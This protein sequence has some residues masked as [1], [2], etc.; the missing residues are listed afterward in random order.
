MLI[1]PNTFFILTF[2]LEFSYF[3]KKIR[4]SWW[5]WMGRGHCQPDTYFRLTVMMM[6]GY[7]YISRIKGDTYCYTDMVRKWEWGRRIPPNPKLLLR[8]KFVCKWWRG[9]GGGGLIRN[10]FWQKRG[11]FGPKQ[12]LYPLLSVF[13]P[14]L[15]ISSPLWSKSP[16]WGK[17][18]ENNLI[19]R[20][21][22]FNEKKI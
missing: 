6:I 21:L 3:F 13:S 15:S 20:K 16:S 17:G 2:F 10:I 22:F 11:V 1:N 18:R 9:E 12:H 8:Q 4:L 19:S 7:M 5:G 14:L